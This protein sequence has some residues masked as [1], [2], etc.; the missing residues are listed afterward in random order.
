MGGNNA[1]MLHAY[2]YY[3]IHAMLTLTTNNGNILTGSYSPGAISNTSTLVKSQTFNALSS[4]L[5]L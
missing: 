1:Q 3:T 2:L 4:R 5:L